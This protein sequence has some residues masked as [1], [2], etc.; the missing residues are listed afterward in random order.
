[1]SVLCAS[2]HGRLSRIAGWREGNAAAGA[3]V[4]LLPAAGTLPGRKRMG[5][6]SGRGP[7]AP[8]HDKQ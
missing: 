8:L 4:T 5:T 3:W 2:Q 7:A 1:M 6:R